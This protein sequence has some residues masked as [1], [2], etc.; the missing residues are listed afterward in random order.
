M[1][2]GSRRWLGQGQRWKFDLM[3]CEH[4]FEKELSCDFVIDQAMK[5]RLQPLVT[6]GFTD[7]SGAGCSLMPA[8]FR[9]LRDGLGE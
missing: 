9:R 8:M 4:P 5:P 6:G 7:L 3:D 1:H 2:P